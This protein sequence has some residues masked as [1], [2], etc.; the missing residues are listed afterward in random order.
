M[1][2]QDNGAKP[3]PAGFFWR[4]ANAAP[5]PSRPTVGTLQLFSDARCTVPVATPSN[6]GWSSAAS[7]CSASGCEL[8]SGWM[9]SGSAGA[10]GCGLAIDSNGG[11]SWRPQDATASD[12]S[13]VA[14]EIWLKLK[15]A[16]PKIIGCV[17]LSGLGQAGHAHE[18]WN[19]AESWKGGLRL[20]ASD[21]GGSWTAQRRAPH[22]SNIG[23][24]D[25]NTFAVASPY[26]YKVEWE[27]SY[28]GW[29]LAPAGA[30]TCDFGDN[31]RHWECNSAVQV[32]ASSS[33]KTKGTYA[34]NPAGEACIPLGCSAKSD[35]SDWSQST[36]WTP[37]YKPT[38]AAGSNCPNFR[39]VCRGQPVSLTNTAGEYTRSLAIK[40]IISL[41]ADHPEIGASACGGTRS[42]GQPL[43]WDYT[44]GSCTS[45]TN[46]VDSGS[47]LHDAAKVWGHRA[48]AVSSYIG[49][50][51]TPAPCCI[52]LYLHVQAKCL[53]TTRVQLTTYS[54]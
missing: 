3:N 44:G 28:R 42:A 18:S 19:I 20:E 31:A 54:D 33:S 53:H 23:T 45:G 7:S 48:D 36:T 9:G 15:F 21:D 2:S 6:G 1:I 12:G 14:G 17:I 26:T 41:P 38:S 46:A 34:Y 29:H 40:P 37:L 11:T 25:A 24:K 35:T 5:V 51:A 32:L 27:A 16:E 49:Q 52:K 39:L 13:Y 30:A 8:C 22:S 50:F 10:N 43:G 4:I 47:L